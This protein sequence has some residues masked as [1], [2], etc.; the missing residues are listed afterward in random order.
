MRS[1][2]L[3][4]LV[5]AEGPF[6]SV[7][8]DDSHNT[9]DAVEVQQTQW[10]DIRTRL[11]DMGAGAQL[12]ATLDDA[13][14]NH[15][16]AVGRRGR[17]VIATAERV[18]INEQL[19][20][21]A[22]MV[23]LSDYPYFLPL[24]DLEMRRPTYV[25]AA[26]DHAGA[27]VSLCQDS[28]VGSERID[29]AG[30]PV[31]KPV[32][33]GWKGYGDFQRTT[34]EAVRM[35]CRAVADHLTRLVDEAN[36][37]VV[38]LC[39]DARALAEL[40]PALPKRVADRVTQLHAGTCK[41]G[42]GEEEIRGL[43]SAEFD[44]RRDTEIADTAERFEAEIGRASGLAAEG[45]GAVCAAL[46]A[47]DVDTLIVGDLGDATVVTARALTT[48]APDPDA[49]SELG[50][51]VARVARADEALPFAAVAV[52][53]NVVRADRRIAPTDGVGAVLRYTAERAD[54]RGA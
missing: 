1:E 38:F 12:L 46:R 27:D 50:E 11:E 39:G 13:V 22:T 30:Y 52:D 16:P 25:F 14:L 28:A 53:G 42:I 34:E 49:L 9:L 48:I 44:R 23:R 7:Y 32:T 47:G 43:T 51:P 54:Q 10:H 17:A 2:R 40:V 26:V 29:G 6:A 8:F 33:A 15:R 31:H 24:I 4:G 5:E 45:L 18:L 19:A 35:N 41:R 20:A 37:E 36:P 21:P 3:K